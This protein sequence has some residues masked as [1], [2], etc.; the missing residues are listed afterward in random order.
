M[1]QASF[2]A[3]GAKFLLWALLSAALATLLLGLV[4]AGGWRWSNDSLRIN[5]AEFSDSQ[6]A[7]TL[8]GRAVRLDRFNAEG[9]QV[10]LFPDTRARDLA[11]YRYLRL[12]F[13]NF[14]ATHR[15]QMSW[16]VEGQTRASRAEV[17]VPVGGSVWIDLARLDGFDPSAAQIA[18]A[19]GPIAFKYSP[20]AVPRDTLFVAADFMQASVSTALRA[21]AAQSMQFAPEALSAV[22]LTRLGGQTPPFALGLAAALVLL[23]WV[24]LAWRL[25]KVSLLASAG[26]VALVGWIVLDQPRMQDAYAEARVINAD[27]AGK[28][29]ALRAG[30]AFDGDLKQFIDAFLLAYQPPAHTTRILV[31]AE[32]VPTYRA[33]YFLAPYNSAPLANAFDHQNGLVS[34]DVVLFY[35][36]FSD[37]IDGNQLWINRGRRS[38]SLVFSDPRGSAFVLE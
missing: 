31:V 5:G 8:A 32:E 6:G 3:N 21:A 23:I 27:F 4:L 30:M 15:V 20:A 26:M 35:G 37:V 18:L 16:L 19:V 38:A 29:F 22:N 9:A 34:G 25:L 28:P 24:I 1:S 17:G 2:K 13:E 33:L 7:P 12:R 14:P 36:M 10:L 11:R